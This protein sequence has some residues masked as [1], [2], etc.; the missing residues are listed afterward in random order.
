MTGSRRPGVPGEA[1]R[2][3]AGRNSLDPRNSGGVGGAIHGA[4]SAPAPTLIPQEKQPL[5]AFARRL[6]GPGVFPYNT[7]PAPPAHARR[8]GHVFPQSNF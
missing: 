4:I 2:G 5:R 3:G 6:A 8:H 7:A 1:D